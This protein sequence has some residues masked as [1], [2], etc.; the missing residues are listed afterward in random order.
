MP[1]KYIFFPFAI[2][3]SRIVTP[4]SSITAR[5]KRILGVITIHG[6]NVLNRAFSDNAKKKK[7][8]CFRR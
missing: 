5:K 2:L 1:D 6:N 4:H 7:L 8:K 3:M